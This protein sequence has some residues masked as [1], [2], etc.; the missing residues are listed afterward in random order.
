MGGE[1]EGRLVEDDMSRDDDT[2]SGQVK[3]AIPL[4][5]EGISKK[6]TGGGARG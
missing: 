6:N 3:T 5:S 2:S 1:G 4:M